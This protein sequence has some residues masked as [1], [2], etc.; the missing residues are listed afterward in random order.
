MC[1]Y[2]SSKNDKYML[3]F[4]KNQGW[5]YKNQVITKKPS[6]PPKGTCEGSLKV[7]FSKYI[8]LFKRQSLKFLFLHVPCLIFSEKKRYP[9]SMCR[10]KHGEKAQ[11]LVTLPTTKKS[12]YK[13]ELV[14]QREV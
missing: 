6:S 10:R 1:L 12:T 11:T 13:R 14:L 3:K 5:S 7:N 8:Y 9:W 2:E 4:Y